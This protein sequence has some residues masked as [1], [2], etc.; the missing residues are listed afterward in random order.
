M[1]VGSTGLYLTATVAFFLSVFF[2]PLASATPFSCVLQPSPPVHLLPMM[3]EV[4][5]LT[6]LAMMMNAS[7]GASCFGYIMPQALKERTHHSA[8]KLNLLHSLFSLSLLS[9]FVCLNTNPFQK[10]VVVLSF[11]HFYLVFF[12]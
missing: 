10:L 9:S 8:H 3:K 1:P 12:S 5:C 6:T 7:G 11:K 4:A 2:L